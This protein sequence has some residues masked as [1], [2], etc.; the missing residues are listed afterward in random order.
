MPM[1]PQMYA[2]FCTTL[3]ETRIN[4]QALQNYANSSRDPN[5]QKVAKNWVDNTNRTRKDL[6][7]FKK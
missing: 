4:A 3:E 1:T 5:L 7:C 6:E 2:H